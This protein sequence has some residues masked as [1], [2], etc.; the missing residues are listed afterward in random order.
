M[1][2]WVC[3][4]GR[5]SLQG[6]LTLSKMAVEIRSGTISPDYEFLEAPRQSYGALK[7]ADDC[8][9]VRSFDLRDAPPVSGTQS[10]R[11]W[12]ATQCND[13]ELFGRL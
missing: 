5:P 6:P 10:W 8:R 2:Y 3:T 7:R 11:K 4:T 9:T 13:L 12:Q 1:K